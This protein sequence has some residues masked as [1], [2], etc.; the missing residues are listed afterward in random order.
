MNKRKNPEDLLIAYPTIRAKP[1]AKTKA[2]TNARQRGEMTF[3]WHCPKHGMAVFS[4]A[5]A[6][7]CRQCAAENT[8]AMRERRRA[9]QRQA[10]TEG[11]R[12][13]SLR[14]AAKTETIAAA[15]ATYEE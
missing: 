5:G 14:A 4:T 2:R 8:R 12:S 1:G 9:E 11:Q 7:M 13:A 15:A 10:T 6:G 3:H